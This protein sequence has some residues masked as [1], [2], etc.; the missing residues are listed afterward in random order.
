MDYDLFFQRSQEGL[1]IRLTRVAQPAR[2]ALLNILW[3]MLL[4]PA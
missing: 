4:P 3:G 2:E 1:A